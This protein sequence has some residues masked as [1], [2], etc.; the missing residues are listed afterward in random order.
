MP[1]GHTR[2]VILSGQDGLRGEQAKESAADDGMMIGSCVVP[3]NRGDRSQWTSDLTIDLG[4]ENDSARSCAAESLPMTF[5]FN[6]LAFAITLASITVALWLGLFL[7]TRA[8]ESPRAWLSALTV[9]VV[10]A[11]FIH[12]VLQASLPDYR[13]VAWLLWFG[14]AIKFAPTLWFHLSCQLL[15]ETTPVS[16][17]QKLLLRWVVGLSYGIT[18]LQVVDTG[19]GFGSMATPEEIPSYGLFL[20]LLFVL[21]LW[22]MW[23]FY[24]ALGHARFPVLRRQFRHL[25]VATAVAYV[26]GLVTGLGIYLRWNLYFFPSYAVLAIGVI[27]L[28][29]GVVKYDALVEGR[30]I[31]RDALYSIAGVG[32]VTLFYTLVG[33]ILWGTGAIG[34]T[35]LVIFLVCAVITH[36]LSDGGR[37]IL[38]RLFYRGHL[39]K[40]RT[41]LRQLA[42]ETGTS[43]TL[44]EQLG[45]VL[46]TVCQSV[47]AGDGFIAIR[48]AID[49]KF[50]VT[51]SRDV[52]WRE[53]EWDAATLVAREI[54][55]I[56]EAGAARSELESMALLVPLA[57]NRGQN[58]ALVVGRKL[59]GAPYRPEEFDYLETVGPQLAAMIESAHQ[60]EARV[61]QLEQAMEEYRARERNLQMQMQQLVTVPTAT[62]ERPSDLDDERMVT[63]TEDALRHLNDFAYLGEHDLVKLQVVNKFIAAATPNQ[64]LSGVTH[65]D[66]GKALHGLLLQAVE[67]LRPAG[68]EPKNLAVPSREWHNFLILHDNYVK[69]DLTRDIMAR[70]YIGEGTYNRTRRRALRSVAKAIQ[71]MEQQ[72]Q[73]EVAEQV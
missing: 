62:V 57:D 65:V 11:W 20:A 69:G 29:Y 28:G 52:R 48:Q 39:R 67:A 14:Q 34:I 63:L 8:S 43:N 27:L 3:R 37:T 26:G 40:L 42:Q 38:D 59:S 73:A 51:N 54:I 33:L 25:L 71:E 30:S 35:A 72:A 17:R 2:W 64:R 15:F 22:A 61:Q 16:R 5:F 24:R 45:L 31:E 36:T 18:L 13:E 46:E 60:Q 68:A 70:L 66:Q 49:P 23:N 41:D 21:P 56:G 55:E 50:V 58:G 32:I 44:G 12:N 47:G 10:G 9:W 4:D 6:A 7:V 53:R 19:R 1:T